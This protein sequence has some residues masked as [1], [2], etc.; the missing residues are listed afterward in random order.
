[1]P[2]STSAVGGTAP[3]VRPAT[4]VREDR[5]DRENGPRSVLS[6]FMVATRGIIDD[7]A[8]RGT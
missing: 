7:R 1:M 4:A 3:K 6:T 2:S 5:E 8:P